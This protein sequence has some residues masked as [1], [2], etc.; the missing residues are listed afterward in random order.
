MTNWIKTSERMPTEE[1]TNIE[2]HVIGGTID[3]AMTVHWHAIRDNPNGWPMWQPFPDPPE[4]Q[5]GDCPFC[6][7]QLSIKNQE[8]RIDL[9]L[10]SVCWA[11]CENEK[12]L[13]VE[14]PHCPTRAEAIAASRKRHQC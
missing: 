5:A 2:S 8:A 4:A 12:C 11:R 1:D 10:G 13:M 6:G 14:G 3:E 7:V 9:Q